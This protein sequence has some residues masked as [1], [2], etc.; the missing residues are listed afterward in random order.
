MSQE[1]K[2][3]PKGGWKTDV[4]VFGM[5]LVAALVA[6][7]YVSW[8][9]SQ[10]GTAFVEKKITPLQQTLAQQNQHLQEQDKLIKSL[11]QQWQ[12]NQQRSQLRQEKDW[13][14]PEVDY[15]VNLA[16][17]NLQIE[18]NIPLARQVL[19]TADRRVALLHDPRLLPLREALGADLAAL[20]VVP[21]V[22]VAGLVIYL[23]ALS[24][25][26]DA[27][28]RVPRLSKEPEAKVAPI[29]AAS[30]QERFK[31]L[32]AA[33]GQTLKSL[34]VIHYQVGNAPPLLAPDQYPFVITNIQSQ[35]ALAQ[36]AVLHHQPEV[37]Q[38]SLARA[39]TWIAQYFPS[40]NFTVQTL[41]QKLR[42]LQKI[43]VKS[44]SLPD[45]S[46]SVEAIR[47]L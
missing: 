10:R 29:Q 4:L 17:F 40:D 31:Q 12:E 8:Q 39:R 11:Q 30:W 3:K 28:P 2:P 41:L 45:L 37:F 24:Q 35:L 38:Q 32:V 14:L 19:Q 33:I 13:V 47:R 9:I 16:A 23:N 18:N 25:Q 34:L 44:P 21:I 26:V 15:L 1:I 20:N 6:A 7:F 22:D 36:W 46:R 27:L 43:S 42:D 5:V